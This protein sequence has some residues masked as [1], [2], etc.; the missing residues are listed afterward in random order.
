MDVN[1]MHVLILGLGISG[2][3]TAKALKKLG[4]KISIT[5]LKK[6]E[7]LKDYINQL[8]GMDVNLILGTN[9]V[10][11]DGVDLIVKSPGIPLKIDIIKEA[12]ERSIDVITDLELAYRLFPNRNYIAITGTNGKTT[13]TTLTGQLFKEAG[14]TTHV[15]GNIGVGILWD[16]INSQDEDVFVIETSSFQL[17][18]T[19]EFKPKISV[20]LNIT[21]DHIDWHGSYEKYIEAKKKI[22][23]NQTKDEYTVLNYDDMQLRSLKDEVKSNLVW[24]SVDNVLEKGVYIEDNTIVIKDGVET[25]KVMTIDEIQI[26]GKHNLENVLASVS[27]GW[28]MGLDIDVM[29]K[30]IREFKGVKH[31]IEYVASIN[32]VKYYNDSKGTNPDASIKAI[33]AVNPPIILIAGG[34]DKGV[35]FDEFI[36]SF[37]ERVKDLVLLGE[38]K[39]KIRETALRYGFKNIHLVNTIREAVYKSFQLAKEGDNVLLSPACTSWD[40]YASYEERGKDFKKAVFDLKE[41]ENG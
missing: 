40:M 26:L 24:F 31:R 20:I 7:E 34:K 22:F 25:H 23:I 27:V 35:P 9:S 8:D 29:R 39:D 4:A 11:L 6:E 5:D 41:E 10:P 21:P 36:Q 37:N 16:L 1:N 13:T 30:A 19:Y 12:K 3:S 15:S 33:K 14:F 32:G 17:E 38:A 28:I 18:N 2:V